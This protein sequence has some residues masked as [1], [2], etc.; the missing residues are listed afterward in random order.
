VT[1][2]DIVEEL[3]GAISDEFDERVVPLRRL[4]GG[5]I[6]VSGR[7]EV[8]LVNEEMSWNLPTGNYETISGMILERLGRF[9]KDGEKLQIGNFQISILRTDKLRIRF[10]KIKPMKRV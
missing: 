1:M 6:L 2:E 7:S 3:F 4:T 8:Y 5:E 10:V 9:P